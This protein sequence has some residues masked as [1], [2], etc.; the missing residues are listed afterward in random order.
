[1]KISSMLFVYKIMF[2][3][4]YNDWMFDCKRRYIYPLRNFFR[5]EKN[6]IYYEPIGYSKLWGWFG[7]SYASW[8]TI[9]RVLAHAMPDKWQEKMAKLLNEYDEYWDFSKIDLSVHV[10]T[11]RNGKFIN[12]CSELGDYR[13]PDN[14]YIESLKNKEK[15]KWM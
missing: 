1:M 6:K 5:K 15:M 4:K 3:H 14:E 12:I 9:P 2:W 11:K 7:L 8:I 13:H 10:S